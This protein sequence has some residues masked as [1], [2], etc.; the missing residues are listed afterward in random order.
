MDY[1]L[2]ISDVVGVVSDYHD[3]LGEGTTYLSGAHYFTPV[4]VTFVSLNI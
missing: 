3:I 4:F 1:A 2:S